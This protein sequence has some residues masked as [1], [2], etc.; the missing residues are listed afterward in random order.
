MK[1]L[2][3]RQAKNVIKK[4]QQGKRSEFVKFQNTYRGDPVAFIHDC[5]I[6]KEGGGPTFY[7]DEI[8]ANFANC[9]RQAIRMPR[10]GGKTSLA[11]WYVIYWSLIHAGEDW[12][13]VQTASA[14]RQLEKFLWPEIHK[15]ARKLNWSVIGRGELDRRTELLTQS[16]R[17]AG[18]EAFPIASDNPSATEGVHADHMLYV[19]DEAK[20]IEPPFWDSVEGALEKPGQEYKFLVI[21]T[22]G[23]M[24]TR[25]HKIHTRALGYE[26]WYVRHVTIDEVVKAGRRTWDWVEKR[27]RQWGEDSQLFYNHVLGEFKEADEDA[28][29]PF[30]WVEAACKRH[31]KWRESIERGG[32]MGTLTSIG[33][34]LGLG[35]E[36]GDKTV[37]AYCRDENIISKLELFGRGGIA[38]AT[39]ENAGKIKGLVDGMNVDVY[40]DVI[41]IGAGIVARL[42]EQGKLY[43]QKVIPFN[44]AKKPNTKIKDKTGEFKFQNNRSAMWWLAREIFDPGGDF[45]V[46]IPRDDRLIGELIAPHYKILS[47]ATI[48]VETKEDIRKRLQRST[49]RADAVLQ[50]L[51]G[52]RLSKRK[53]A[54]VYVIGRGYVD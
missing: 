19:F 14:W 54:Q 12:R 1:S 22:P 35:G 3:E 4:V 24:N 17:L 23:E 30:A 13:S 15:W 31:D 6:W 42:H 46:A 5:F 28:L 45:N 16:L 49:D 11:A 32:A 36:G 43:K 48:Q 29:I 37:Y 8:L 52:P 34:D 33:V 2:R 27:K 25:F 41:N 50:A 40:P 20:I 53:K 38:N 51:L 21:S 7:Q 39:M 10:G 26:E 18:G 47:N 44:A 9:D